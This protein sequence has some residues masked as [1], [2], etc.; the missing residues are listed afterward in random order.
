[1]ETS[2]SAGSGKKWEWNFQPP[3]GFDEEP[4][5]PDFAPCKNCEGLDFA[6]DYAR[7]D[8]I[9]T[10]CGYV[11]TEHLISEEAYFHDFEDDIAAGVSHC[12]VGEAHGVHELV[13]NLTTTAAGKKTQLTRD[14][15]EFL[16]DGTKNI[17]QL[18]DGVFLNNLQMD[19][20]PTP[21]LTRAEQL[22]QMAFLAQRAQMKAFVCDVAFPDSTTNPFHL[23]DSPED[24]ES[25]SK[26]ASKKPRQRF[27][28]RKQ[29]VIAFSMQALKENHIHVSLNA[30]NQ[31]MGWTVSR[32]SV[33]KVLKEVGLI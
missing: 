13:V 29:Y 22:F 19:R 8:V 11:Q 20:V 9:C 15:N 18:L 7:G 3:K 5:N 33:I 1:L 10:S 16:L 4:T 28:K 31:I 6:E 24:N 26:T 32:A 14:E 25:G 17:K 27:S 21:V 2:S 12:Q 23:P 30:L